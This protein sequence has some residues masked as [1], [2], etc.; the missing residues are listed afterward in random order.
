MVN[1]ESPTQERHFERLSLNQ[2]IQHWTLILSFTTL[3]LT[4]LPVRY[5]DSPVSSIIIQLVGG[6]EVRSVLHRLAAVLLILLT[7]Y[8]IGYSLFTRR[9]RA[10]LLALVP[11]LKDMFDA[12][13]MVMFYFGLS[14]T[15]PKFDRYNFIEKFEYLAVGWGSIV[16]IATGLVLWFHN[17]AMVYLPKWILDVGRVIHSYEALLAF[18]AIIIWHFYHV[19]FNPE[20]FPMSRI[21]LTGK[22]SEHELK[23]LHPLEYERI[24]KRIR[25]AEI[26]G[27]P[28]EVTDSPE[29]DDDLAGG[30]D[31]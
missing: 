6:F 9:G 21:W 2:R 27:A 26:A 25:R 20:V 24:L 4:G 28:V 14:A 13:K 18:L 23:D 15:T 12:I 1:V 16:M 19:H 8:H 7:G 11:N 3:V 17:E 31:D 29:R 5:P 10:E 30:T 22:I